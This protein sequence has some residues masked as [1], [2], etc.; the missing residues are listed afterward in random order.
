MQVYREVAGFTFVL[1]QVVEIRREV[2]VRVTLAVVAK[3]TVHT[4]ALR[5]AGRAEH[6][7]A[8]LANGG[9]GVALRLEQ[10]GNSI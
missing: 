8:P 4:Q 10:L 7:H 6:A 1:G 5:A 3:E 2:A 9:R